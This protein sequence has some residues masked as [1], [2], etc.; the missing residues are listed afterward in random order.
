MGPGASK[1]RLSMERT[2][3]LYGTDNVRDL[4]G[5]YATIAPLRCQGTERED[6]Y[7]FREFNALGEGTTIRG[8]YTNL[9]QAVSVTEF[10]R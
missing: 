6:A 1:Y 5:A 8:L 10:C 7:L 9:E 4:E 3:S 2:S